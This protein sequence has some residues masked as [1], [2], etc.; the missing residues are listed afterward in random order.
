M[1]SSPGDN[2][3][4]DQLVAVQ[5]ILCNQLGTGEGETR[6]SAREEERARGLGET[7]EGVIQQREQVRE[8]AES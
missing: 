6:G 5:D 3:K 7:V 2:R 8:E 4:D 1:I